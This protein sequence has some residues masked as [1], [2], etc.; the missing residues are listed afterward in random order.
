MNVDDRA[1]NDV[2]AAD[3]GAGVASMRDS[4]TF[5]S[6]V[7]D[8]NQMSDAGKEAMGAGVKC[9]SARMSRVAHRSPM[10]RRSPFSC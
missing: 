3:F 9:F 1:A 5:V 7:M 4:L 6:I 2:F 8:A 10:L